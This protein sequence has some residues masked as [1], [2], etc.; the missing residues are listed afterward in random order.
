MQQEVNVPLN[1]IIRRE[2]EDNRFEAFVWRELRA[3]KNR[4]EKKGLWESPK[5]TIA[6][7]RDAFEDG[8]SKWNDT[9]I[10]RHLKEKCECYPVKVDSV[11]LF[12]FLLT[13]FWE[14][15]VPL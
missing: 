13:V 14:I 1:V 15:T 2:Y 12:P 10:R 11:S 9:T 5:I 8:I 6:E 4:L 3:R 7:L